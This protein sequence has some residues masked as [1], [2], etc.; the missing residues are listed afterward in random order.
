MNLTTPP[1]VD[2]TLAGKT[3]TEVR[4]LG[5]AP[6]VGQEVWVELMGGDLLVHGPLQASPAAGAGGDHPDADH[7]FLVSVIDDPIY[8]ARCL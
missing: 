1:T 8:R 5:G 2:L 6:E 4:Y 7:N 3:F